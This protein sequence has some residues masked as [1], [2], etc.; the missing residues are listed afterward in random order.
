MSADNTTWIALYNHI[1]H[2]E[3]QEAFEDFENEEEEEEEEDN[4]ENEHH[5]TVLSTTTHAPGMRDK[6][7]RI[8]TTVV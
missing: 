3:D 2:S 5:M 8:Y 4:E 7:H 1:N 6:S